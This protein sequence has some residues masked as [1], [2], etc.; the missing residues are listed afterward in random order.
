MTPSVKSEAPT[1]PATSILAPTADRWRG[2]VGLSLWVVRAV[3]LSPWVGERGSPVF[4]K[5]GSKR[6][7]IGLFLLGRCVVRVRD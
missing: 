7:A 6:R 2:G 4:R 5:S 3:G 1:T